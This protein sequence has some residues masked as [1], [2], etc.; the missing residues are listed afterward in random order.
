MVNVLRED[1]KL[2][3]AQR[4]FL[5]DFNKPRV[6]TYVGVKKQETGLRYA[7]VLVIEEGNVAGGPPRVET[8]SFK[9]R[10][11]APLVE[12]ALEAQMKAD[13]NEALRKYGGALDIRRDGLQP[14]LRGGREV[15]V[16]RIRLV[17]EGGTLKPKDE[18]V[19]NVAVEATRESF[20]GVEVLF[21]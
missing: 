12:N 2:P 17:Y 1:A 7:D 3:R 20:P 13:A 5:G 10:N 21:Q 4:R 11:L 6:E 14:L 16:Q 19:L 8:F 18:H 9:S 15:L